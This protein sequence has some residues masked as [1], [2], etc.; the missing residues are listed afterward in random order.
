MYTNKLHGESRISPA[1]L[2]QPSRTCL[3]D[4]THASLTLRSQP[5]PCSCLVPDLYKGKIGVDKEEASHLLS[6]L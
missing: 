6:K 3:P 5:L 1:W 4:S 2:V